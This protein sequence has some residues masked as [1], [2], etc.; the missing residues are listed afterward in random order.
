LYVTLKLDNYSQEIRGKEHD[1]L[2]EALE[3]IGHDLGFIPQKELPHKG[4]RVDLVWLDRDGNVFAA[5]EVETSSQ[6]KKD[7]ISTWETEPKLAIIISHYKSDKGIKDITQYVLL[8][9]MPHK[10]LFINNTNKKAYLID[11][12]NI[13]RYYDIEKKKEIK[14]T[15]DTFEF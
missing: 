6:W 14:T 5:I 2:V 11:R 13:V 7:I 10:L 4:S 12:Q 8:E 1:R 15:S 3:R 9:N